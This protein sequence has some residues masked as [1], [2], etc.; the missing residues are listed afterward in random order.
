MNVKQISMLACALI[1]SS[2]SSM[3]RV[4]AGVDGG[5][6]AGP[7]TSDQ[8]KSLIK[9]GLE[10]AGRTCEGSQV[11]DE[12]SHQ[13]VEREISCLSNQKIA[14]LMAA[15]PLEAAREA[16]R[17]NPNVWKSHQKTFADYFDYLLRAPNFKGSPCPGS[18]DQSDYFENLRD[19]LRAND[20]EN[21]LSSAAGIS[22][23]SL[24]RYQLVIKPFLK[25]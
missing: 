15:Y 22:E 13:F 17:L 23:K 9:D 2:C 18:S 21:D 24:E 1:F 8:V 19:C 3:N 25:P 5:N 14:E 11:Y 20:F 16:A 12:G 7:L 10:Q 4:P 6:G